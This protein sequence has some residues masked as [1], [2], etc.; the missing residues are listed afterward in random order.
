MYHLKMNWRDTYG[1]Y[2]YTCR[3]LLS[4]QSGCAGKSKDRALGNAAFQLFKEA[5]GGTLYHNAYGE[6]AESSPGRN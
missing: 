4:P 5:S 6:H 3:G 2:L 1:N